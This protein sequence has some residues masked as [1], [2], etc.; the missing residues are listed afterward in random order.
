MLGVVF[1]E[2]M[3]MVEE[4]FSP[5]VADRVME[6]VEDMLPSGGAYT[7]VGEYH[8][9]EILTLIGQLSADTGVPVEDLVE[10]FGRYLF[11]RFA[12][13][14]PEFFQGADDAF[15]FLGTIEDYIHR[16]VRKLYPHAELPSFDCDRPS[17]A[18]LIMHYESKRPFAPLAHGLIHGCIDHFGQ[19]IMVH[20]DMPEEKAGSAATFTLRR[21]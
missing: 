21:T 9:S 15:T 8:H 13:L 14:Y 19:E 12:V 1:S 16:E 6:Q 11:A 2:F 18:V 3:E 5:D 20:M 4:E 17:D 10:K 7:A